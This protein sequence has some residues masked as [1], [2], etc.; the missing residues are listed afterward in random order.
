MSESKVAIIGMES[1]VRVES[2][3]PDWSLPRVWSWIQ[4]FRQRVTDDFSPRTLDEFVAQWEQLKPLR[5]TWGV[6]RGAEL[7]G[8]VVWDPWP[9]P[10]VGVS[11]A[12]FKREFWGRGTT[13]RA[14]E[15]V[16]GELFAGGARKILG[17]PFASNHAIIGLGKSIGAKTEGVLRKQTLQLGKPVDVVV[18]GLLKEDFDRCRNSLPSSPLSLAELPQSL[19]A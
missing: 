7:G 11:H 14:L 13:K 10:G 4:D 19:A 2:P 3:F 6:W 15:L 8:L 1:A 5:R 9:V 12:L 16:Y 18:L 17:F